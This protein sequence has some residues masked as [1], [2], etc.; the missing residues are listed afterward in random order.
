[1]LLI[2]AAALTSVQCSKE[3]INGD[4]ERPGNE[5]SG[6]TVTLTVR[7]A[8]TTSKTTLA[9]D[10]RVMWE[11]G[12]IVLINGEQH[13]VI[14]DAEDPTLAT[15]PDVPESDGYLAV[16]SIYTASGTI[17]G[18]NCLI[19]LPQTQYYKEGSFGQYANPMIAYSGTTDLEFKNLM[20]V[21][22]LGITGS[23]TIKS[24]TFRSNDGSPLAGSLTIPVQ[25]ITD[26]N[27][28]NWSE[29]DDRYESYQSLTID[30]EGTLV[31]DNSVPAY[32]YFVVPARTYG[33]GFSV[34]LTDTEGN[35]AIQSTENSVTVNRSEIV[36]M[37]TFAF[38]PSSG[39]NISH[40]GSTATSI[41]YTITAEPETPVVKTV[42]SKALWDSYLTYGPDIDEDR[43]AE[44]I[45]NNFQGEEW[46]TETGPDGTFT[47]TAVSAFNSNGYFGGMTAET[48]YMVFAAYSDGTNSIGKVMHI[49]AST[50]EAEGAAPGLEVNTV[51]T[52]YRDYAQFSVII[53]TTDAIDIKCYAMTAERYS[54]MTASGMEDNAIIAE[55]GASVGEENVV[56]ANSSDGLQW[57]WTTD[58]SPETDY[59]I[60]VAATG[61]GGMSAL[62]IL[63]YTT[64]PYLPADAEWH[65]IS[66]DGY[67][68]CGLFSIFYGSLGFSDLTIEQLGE[69][70]IF[71]VADPFMNRGFEESGA[72]EVTD[73]SIILDARTG[74][75]IIEDFANYTGLIHNEYNDG[76]G[77]C[78]ISQFLYLGYGSFG[79]YDAESGIIG[80]GDVAVKLNM[81]SGYYY[82]PDIPTTLWFENPNTDEPDPT[83]PAMSLEGFSIRQESW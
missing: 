12:D 15:I 34:T 16:Y 81:T 45:I 20:G 62:E 55:N 18:D 51:L 74:N 47:E 77:M 82:I 36:P 61:D 37:A 31:L 46:Q 49:S 9:E 24:A 64:P 80:F 41:T 58:I 23:G 21:I 75:V 25:D 59:V 7:S 5:P 3:E 33:S 8:A 19:H 28:Q 71:R 67:M 54:E 72:F 48:E 14:P 26:G 43:I 56:T 27:L 30:T 4:G 17:D 57:F 70:D 52:G 13:E 83:L 63:D 79:T 66:T 11:A 73:G 40:D 42:I 44:E 10:G 35:I 39:I 6:K 29:F 60:M 22:R 78:I 65:T 32:L 76:K 50:T 2:T 38:T 1:M 69:Y 68:E 53:K